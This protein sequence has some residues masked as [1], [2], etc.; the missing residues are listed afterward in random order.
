[1]TVMGGAEVKPMDITLACLCDK[2]S[3]IAMFHV[4]DVHSNRE[5]AVA[6]ADSGH[7]CRR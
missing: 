1:M 7:R 3:E 2:L 4:Y 5:S 6:A